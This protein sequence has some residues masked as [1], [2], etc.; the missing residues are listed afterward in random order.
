MPGRTQHIYLTNKNLKDINPTECGEECCAHDFQ[1]GPT[2][3]QYYLLHYVFS[4]KGTLQAGGKK[5]EVT[6][7][8]I[9]IIHPFEMVRYYVDK[10]DP[11]H[12]AW[13]GFELSFENEQLGDNYVIDLPQSEHIFNAIKNTM[14]VES[15]KT[16]YVCGKIY[17]LISM[18][19]TPETITRS[20]V[21]RHVEQAKQYIDIN[22]RNPISI[23]QIAEDLNINR[24]YFSTIFRRCLGKSPQQYLI[25]V[26]MENAAELIVNYGYK[27]SDA[28][29]SSGYEDIFNFS[30]MFKQR[31]GVSPSQYKRQGGKSN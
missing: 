12:Y 17:E 3:R 6:K 19:Q 7:G 16:L 1:A 21:E 11:W 24:S 8:Q 20:C 26:R 10:D 2:S 31:F 13:V 28:A 30:K 29:Q 18:L 22:F 23:E 25:D 15:D 9:F 4:G 5:F 27:A 14:S